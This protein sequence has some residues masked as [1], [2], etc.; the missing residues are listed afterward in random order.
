LPILE[1]EA[2]QTKKSPSMTNREGNGSPYGGVLGIFAVF[3]QDLQ[4]TFITS[5]S[6]T[7]QLVG[8]KCCQT[9]HQVGCSNTLK[10]VEKVSLTEA[11]AIHQILPKN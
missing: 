11:V 4:K 1:A 8:V 6:A 3:A 7:T 10:N 5:K 2:T 9:H